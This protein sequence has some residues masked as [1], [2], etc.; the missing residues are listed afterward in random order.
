ME[1]FEEHFNVFNFEI[2]GWSIFGNSKGN[3]S[4][5]WL[6][7]RQLNGITSTGRREVLCFIFVGFFLCKL[8]IMYLHHLWKPQEFFIWLCFLSRRSFF[9]FL[10]KKSCELHKKLVWMLNHPNNILSRV[11]QQ[12]FSYLKTFDKSFLLLMMYNIW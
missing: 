1:D 10:Y 7:C 5:F 6:P 3:K 8:Q 9:D 2:E 12:T 11:T 4:V